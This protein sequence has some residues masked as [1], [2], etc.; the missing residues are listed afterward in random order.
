MIVIPSW[1][2]NVLYLTTCIL[3]AYQHWRL[4][5]ENPVANPQFVAIICSMVMVL[6]V[7]IYTRHHPNP[8]VML[9]FFLIAVTGLSLIIRQHRTLPPSRAFE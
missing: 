9:V 5:R 2:T 8:W 7:V 6:V 3:A 1:I 4:N